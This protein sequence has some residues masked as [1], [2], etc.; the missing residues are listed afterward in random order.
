MGLKKHVTLSN[1]VQLNYFRVVCMNVITNQQNTIEV[2]GYTSQ[3][4]RREEQAAYAECSETGSFPEIEVFIDTQFY[5]A[6]YDQEMTIADAY[7]WLKENAGFEQATDIFEEGE[8]LIG[9]EGE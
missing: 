8:E 1:G 6:P 2:A 4:K 7:G 9:G 5:A 3:A